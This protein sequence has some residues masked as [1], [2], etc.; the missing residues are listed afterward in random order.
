MHRITCLYILF[1]KSVFETQLT[2]GFGVPLFERLSYSS[3][4]ILSGSTK[5]N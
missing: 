2:M 1:F 4:S 3:V 5:R